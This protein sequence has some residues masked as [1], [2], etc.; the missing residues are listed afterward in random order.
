MPTLKNMNTPG[1]NGIPCDLIACE[2]RGRVGVRLSDGRRLAVRLEC[3][4]HVKAPPTCPV[5]L[6]PLFAPITTTLVCGHALHWYC[7]SDW[8]N[9]AGID[10]EAAGARCPQCRAYVGLASGKIFEQNTTFLV[11]QALGAIHQNVA[12]LNGYPEPSLEDELKVVVEQMQRVES[13]HANCL[14]SLDVL[15]KRFLNDPSDANGRI[16]YDAIKRTL[17]ICCFPAGAEDTVSSNYTTA[18]EQWLGTL[19]SY[20][21]CNA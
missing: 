12:R 6:D 5:C 4:E 15:R 19:V 10:V 9:T 20:P 3:V 8:R 14:D 16:F 7:L 17:V 21:A 1:Y 11:Y 2:S 13:Q 18:I